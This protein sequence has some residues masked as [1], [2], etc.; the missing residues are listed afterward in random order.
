MIDRSEVSWELPSDAERALIAYCL[1]EEVGRLCHQFKDN[2]YWR[3][4][5][6]DPIVWEKVE[7]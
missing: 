2:T 7:V 1:S 3:L 5:S 4:V 6:A